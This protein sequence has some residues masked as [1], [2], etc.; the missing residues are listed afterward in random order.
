VSDRFLFPHTNA[1]SR[2]AQG[3]TKG[4]FS[5]PPRL[6]FRATVVW[7]RSGREI[8]RSVAFLM[9]EARLVCRMLRPRAEYRSFFFLPKRDMVNGSLSVALLCVCFDLA[10][11][12]LT[13]PIFHSHTAD[14][15]SRTPPGFHRGSHDMSR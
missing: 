8:T 5:E 9:S 2:V 7:T 15:S 11:P 12:S 1:G 4:L 3:A 14:S 13:T 6:F 10:Y